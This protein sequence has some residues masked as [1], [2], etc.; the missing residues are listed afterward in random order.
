MVVS[1]PLVH[2]FKILRKNKIWR[3]FCNFSDPMVEV[4]HLE[5]SGRNGPLILNHWY[6]YFRQRRVLC[7]KLGNK[8]VKILK[9]DS[10]YAQNNNRGEEV[11]LLEMDTY[12]SLDDIKEIRCNKC[13][14]SDQARP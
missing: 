6:I 9:F 11:R 4:I 7:E 5:L 2:N 10:S 12:P 13:T 3:S 14:R 1:F 8:C